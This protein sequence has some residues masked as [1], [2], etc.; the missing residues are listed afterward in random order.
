MCVGHLGLNRLQCCCQGRLSPPVRYL[1]RT[2][3]VDWKVGVRVTEHRHRHG[4]VVV[5][6]TIAMATSLTRGGCVLH[7]LYRNCLL[8]PCIERFVPFPISYISPAF[9]HLQR[10][11]KLIFPPQHLNI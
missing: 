2:S 10:S 9:L 8:K 11:A 1:G 4:Y 6:R 3:V 7:F 5:P